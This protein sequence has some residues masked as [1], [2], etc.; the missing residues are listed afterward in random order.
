ME[1]TVATRVL[2][3]D[4]VMVRPPPGAGLL[5]VTVP[6]EEA[7]PVTAIGFTVTDA[8]E[9]PGGL[10]SSVAFASVLKS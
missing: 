5:R 7:P 9:F 10:T 8:T 1:G 4:N 3:L 2:L 6:V